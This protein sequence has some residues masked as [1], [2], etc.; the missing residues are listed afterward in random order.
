MRAE[1]E[2]INRDELFAEHW[3]PFETMFWSTEVKRGGRSYSRLDLGLRFFLMA[4]TGELVDA[5]RVNEEYRRWITAQ[6]PRYASVKDELTDFRRHAEA[7]RR[8][9]EPS[10]TALPSTDLRR[11]L[12][13]FDVSTALPLVLHLELD[14][15]L[16][17]KETQGALA[18]LESFIARRAILGE[19]NKEYNKFFVEVVKAVKDA[20]A[21]DLHA[22]LAKKLLAGVGTTR[23]WP[24]DE[25]LIEQ[26]IEKP[27]G[28]DLRGPALRLILERLEIAS[29]G[30]KTEDLNVASG[31]QIEHV[32]P[33]K[34]FK[35]WQLKGRDIPEI[36]AD[37]PY[38]AKEELV[39]L[40][41]AI[42]SRNRRVQSLGNL[43]LLN[44]YLNPAASNGSF[45]LKL[46]EYKHSV[47][48]LNRYFD[49]AKSWDEEAIAKRGRSLGELICK[50][51]PR[52][53]A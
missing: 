14:A 45:D 1:K 52:P 43:T 36:V 46:V 21:G 33:Q 37:A 3:S 13:D 22:T 34:W 48:R 20:T 53:T 29:R 41:E 19:E 11:I 42:R 6:P 51:W 25:E 26:V 31:L 30:K 4:K 40:I 50:I 35:H 24:T 49:A 9:E 32:M 27:L 12:I 16:T 18:L 44:G 5:R 38:L 2:K 23:R 7:Y 17:E 15:G 28:N 39:E 47:L 8:Y 10:A